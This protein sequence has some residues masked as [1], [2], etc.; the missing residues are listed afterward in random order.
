MSAS[1]NNLIWIDLEMTGLDPQRDR[2]IEIATLVTDA[3]LNILAEGPVIAVHQSDEQLAL[4]DDWNVRTHTGSG[5]V[6][7]VKA[8]QLDDRAAELETLAFLREW[9]PPG[10]SPICGNSV[11]QD[12]RFLFKYMAELE[13]YFH[14]RYLDVSTL[15]ELARR[16]KPDILPGFK[17]Q[18][19]HQALDDIRE[20][21]AELAYYREN[22]IKL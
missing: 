3:N 2:I 7:R 15:K 5:L 21:V 11:G 18:N 20:S 8:S 19:T 1:E 12:R 13:A 10:I 9:V 4:M 16:W 22:F 17:K 6:E 14:Y